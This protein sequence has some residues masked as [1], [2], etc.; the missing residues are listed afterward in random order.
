MKKHFNSLTLANLGYIERPSDIPI[1]LYNM[2]SDYNILP[3]KQ[4][5]RAILALFITFIR[6]KDT[7]KILKIS[8]SPLKLISQSQAEKLHKLL[9]LEIKVKFAYSKP[10]LKN[11]FL[12]IPMFN[13]FSFT[14][15]GK[16]LKRS[17]KIT[18][19]FCI[20]PIFF[21]LVEKILNDATKNCCSECA[22][23]LSAH[24][25]PLKLLK[26]R[27]DPYLNDLETFKN[28]LKKRINKPIYLSFQSKLGPI[29]W[30]EPSTENT[31]KILSKKYRCIVVF[32]ISFTAENTETIHEIDRI[33]KKTATRVGV[34][35]IRLNCFN[36]DD[37]FIKLLKEVYE[38][39]L[40]LFI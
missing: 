24:S 31:L 10:F 21:D 39:Y 35:L 5:I 25:L 38:G 30:L 8:K 9:Q 29:K 12:T 14:T 37:N 36:D 18:P 34:N 40:D 20:Y 28:Y 13:F 26:E 3:L 27:K 17:K 22:I 11:E 4:P 23:L 2:F 16:I 6:F 7:Y 1:F 19:P 15:H 32:P 33:Y